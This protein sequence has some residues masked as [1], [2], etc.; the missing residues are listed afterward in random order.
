MFRTVIFACLAALLLAACS[1]APEGRDV[2]AQAK[3]DGQIAFDVVKIDDAVLATSLAQGQP[4]FPERFKQYTPPPALKIGIGD[5]VSV[6]IW[7]ASGDGLF[8]ESLTEVSLP[9]GAV[10]RRLLSP[11]TP[12]LGSAA[13]ALQELAPALDLSLLLG[14]NAAQSTAPSLDLSGAIFGGATGQAS[15]GGAGQLPAGGAA[16]GAA[17]QAPAGAAALLAPLVAGGT[18]AQ[19][20]LSNGS[21]PTSALS[22]LQPAQR[23]V[24][25]SASNGNLE[26]LLEAAVQSGR[27][28]TRIPDQQVGLDGAISIPYAGR[29]VAAGH[30]PEEVQRTIEQRLASK[31]I[32]PQALVV[33]SRN[34]ANSVS[35]EGEIV[36]GKRLALSPGGERLLQLIAA[37]G[38]AR[39]PVH[40]TFVRL[41]R[42]GVTATVPLATLVADPAQDIFAEPGDV[43]TLVRRPQTFSVFGATG[44]NTAITFNS[45][46]LS[47]SEALAKAGGLLDDRADPSAVFLFRYEPVDVVR[48]LGQPV[49]TGAPPGLSPIA[50]RLDLREAKSYLLARQFAVHDKDIIFV[51]DAESQAVY[52]FFLV[53]SQIVGPVETGL[54]TCVNANVKC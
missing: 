45:E 25:E 5:I 4:S 51:A 20:G 30:T 21:L 13:A 35:V 26:A 40:E 27:P 53:L 19:Q 1:I 14:G 31:A 15:T 28:G 24:A 6:V 47:L 52:K 9:P 8:G 18:L 16:A 34:F 49:A 7:E 46:K 44:K 33:I 32:E 12:P 17:G 29:I 38:G 41:S 37:A 43:L 11:A 36:G 2:I 23:A 54:L 22:A 42:G 39:A 50:Y 48:A 10:T 3:P